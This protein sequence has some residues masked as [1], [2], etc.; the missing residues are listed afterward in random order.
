MPQ[1]SLKLVWAPVQ[2]EGD[3]A[4]Y[5]SGKNLKIVLRRPKNGNALNASMLA[6]IKECYQ[7]AANDDNISRIVLTAEGKFF[8]TGMDLGKST[9]AVGRGEGAASGAFEQ[10]TTLFQTIQDSP[11][12]TIAAINGMCYAGGIGLAFSSDIRLATANATMALSE[13]RLGLCPAIISKYLVRE[14]GLA[15]TREAM[16][17]G[18]KI[19]MAELKQIG[20]VHDLA[21]DEVGLNVL[22]DEYLV[23]LSNCAPGASKMCKELA[24]EAWL[25]GGT[26]EQD[27]AIYKVFNNMMGPD[28][29]S[30]V[31]LRNFQSGKRSTDWDSFNHRAI[32]SKL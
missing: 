16:L 29:E 26:A 19:S 23:N 2:S 10:F 28:S 7:K 31:G 18:R 32:E 1:T 24:Q 15:F 12:V 5:K 8:C 21:D 20:A 3:I 9:T 11:K 25:R 4:I 6:Q 14:W 27:A 17:S 13:V 30:A 22:L